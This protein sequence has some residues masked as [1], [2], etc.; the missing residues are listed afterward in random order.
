MNP[1]LATN[2]QSPLCMVRPARLANTFQALIYK[3]TESFLVCSMLYDL[4][5]F[6]RVP[7]A[8]MTIS[9]HG[10]IQSSTSSIK[11]WAKDPTVKRG[12]LR[13][14]IYTCTYKSLIKHY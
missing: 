10:D 13:L 11:V 6:K 9:H 1:I 4:K 3:S 7:A 8:S 14:D 12:F 5:P 2:P